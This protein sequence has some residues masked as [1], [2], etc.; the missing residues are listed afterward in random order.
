MV[1]LPVGV[2]PSRYAVQ[3]AMSLDDAHAVLRVG[4][5]LFLSMSVAILAAIGLSGA[6]LARRALRPIDRVVTRARHIGEANLTERLPHPGTEG[7]DSPI[8]LVVAEGGSGVA[9]PIVVVDDRPAV[10]EV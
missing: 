3:V 9:N 6:L 8:E 4:R 7:I 5:W 2:G 10:G 1:S